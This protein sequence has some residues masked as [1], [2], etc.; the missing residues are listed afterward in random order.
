MC[1][2]LSIFFKVNPTINVVFLIT[3]NLAV[4]FF[5]CFFFFSE[6]AIDGEFDI[7]EEIAITDPEE[8]KPDETEKKCT[9]GALKPK[10]KLKVKTKLVTPK[11][12]AAL[13]A[14]K[15]SNRDA[16]RILVAAV[17]A[18]GGNVQ[19]TNVSV[20]TVHRGRELHHEEKAEE[21]KEKFLK[22]LDRN[23]KGIVH[24]DGK[25]IKDPTTGHRLGE[26][27]PILFTCPGI[28]EQLLG[29]PALSEGTGKD[30]GTAVAEALSDWTLT[31]HTEGMCCDTTASNTG[32]LLFLASFFA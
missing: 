2:R 30:I 12:A 1:I 19:T 11:L 22:N 9:A 5:V 14:G 10:T 24:C 8:N 6:N 21:I 31:D 13:D 28:D 26:R 17:E 25:K 7:A 18:L 29:S 4:P 23:A 15:V 16:T 3:V 27:L 32:M 20:A